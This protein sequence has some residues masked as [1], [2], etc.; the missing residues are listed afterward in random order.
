MEDA[1]HEAGRQVE[2]SLSNIA[3]LQEGLRLKRQISEEEER[4]LLNPNSRSF[5][6]TRQ[7]CRSASNLLIKLSPQEEEVRNKAS[8]QFYFDDIVR[9]NRLAEMSHAAENNDSLNSEL[10]LAT[11]LAPVISTPLR[12]SFRQSRA[13]NFMEDP[14]LLRLRDG[15]KVKRRWSNVADLDPGVMRAWNDFLNYEATLPELETPMARSNTSKRGNSMIFHTSD[16]YNTQ[17]DQTD[18]SNLPSFAVDGTE[19]QLLMESLINQPR[20]DQSTLL[21][22]PQSTHEAIIELESSSSKPS[23]NSSGHSFNSSLGA[24][25]NSR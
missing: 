23:Q 21:T 11:G 17:L 15:A 5:L 18:F 20:H 22:H 13:G 24:R 6:G 3:S 2:K 1:N 14:R 8:K 16:V 19:T 12:A 4:S 10:E 7:R 9:R 25:S